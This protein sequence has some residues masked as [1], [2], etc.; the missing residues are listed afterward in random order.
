[1]RLHFIVPGNSLD[2][3]NFSFTPIKDEDTPFGFRLDE[4]NYNYSNDQIVA[5]RIVQLCAIGLQ[6]G[7]KEVL[8]PYNKEFFT[9]PSFWPLWTWLKL[10]GRLEDSN[11]KDLLKY[12]AW[13]L[14]FSS[15]KDALKDMTVES[16]TST[17]LEQLKWKLINGRKAK[18][19]LAYG[20]LSS[21]EID[22]DDENLTEEQVVERS[23]INNLLY[24]FTRLQDD[25]E[26]FKNIIKAKDEFGR[27]D[28]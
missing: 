20:P 4:N 27:L 10:V 6:D 3:D 9:C 23:R 22:Y 25:L 26:L 1:M 12:K 28:N 2:L 5:I 19:A 11:E 18:A 15:L 14:A 8:I 21:L 16:A 13:S 24:I 17:N 7:L